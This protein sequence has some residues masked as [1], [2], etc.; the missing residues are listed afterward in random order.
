MMMEDGV[1]LHYRENDGSALTCILI[2]GLGEGEFVWEKL[3]PVISPICNI[4][5][6]D[7]RGHGESG[8]SEDRKYNHERYVS[9]IDNLLSKLSIE[10][11][12][13]MGHSL[14]GQ[15]C[16]SIAKRLGDSLSGL[17]VVDSSPEVDPAAVDHLLADFRAEHRPY[18]SAEE[19]AEL[20]LNKRPLLVPDIARQLASGAL[21]RADDGMYYLKRDPALGEAENWDVGSVS[22]C[23]QDLNRISCPALLLRGS[24]SA[25]LRRSTAEAVAARFL[26]CEHRVIPVSGHSVMLDNPDGFNAVVKDFIQ[27]NSRYT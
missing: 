4:V 26:S 11:L 10:N 9:D 6:V 23:W 8:W 14:G 15:I 25:V 20:L 19:Y 24:G 27:L 17:I 22:D 21:R 18:A 13:L 7:I 16:L 2:H 12:I 3:L 5:S 1:E